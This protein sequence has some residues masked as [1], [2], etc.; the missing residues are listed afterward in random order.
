VRDTPEQNGK[1]GSRFVAADRATLRIARLDTLT[2]LYH[3]A[4]GITHVVDS[5][6]PELIEALEQPRTLNGL[7][8]YLLTEYDV[9]DA[10]RAALTER[11]AE[12]EAAGIVERV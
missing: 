12:L 8:D 4:S 7:L 11:L 6:V 9:G 2:A 10:D 3:R 1:G 5:P